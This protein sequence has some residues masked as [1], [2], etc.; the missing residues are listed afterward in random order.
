LLP[1]SVSRDEAEHHG[2]GERFDLHDL[3][4]WTSHT[5]TSSCYTILCSQ[6]VAV[7]GVG[8]VVRSSDVFTTIPT[9]RSRFRTIARP[10]TPTCSPSPNLSLWPVSLSLSSWRG[11]YSIEQEVACLGPKGCV[12]FFTVLISVPVVVCS[13]VGIPAVSLLQTMSKQGSYSFRPRWTRP[14]LVSGSIRLVSR[15]MRC[16]RRPFLVCL[17]QNTS[18]CHHTDSTDSYISKNPPTF[19][20]G[21]CTNSMLPIRIHA[22]NTN[23]HVSIHNRWN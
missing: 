5:H 1:S 19:K 20:N 6:L 17:S 14:R 18:D 10:C 22:V 16:L 7:C 4:I 8:E 11:E 23:P 13:P 15:A 3:L 2:R 12:M 9:P 21:I